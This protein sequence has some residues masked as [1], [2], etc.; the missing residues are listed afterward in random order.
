MVKVSKL[1]TYFLSDAINVDLVSFLSFFEARFSFKV[2]AG[3]F[4]ASLLLCC[5]FDIW[6]TPKRMIGILHTGI[7]LYCK[8]LKINIDIS[9]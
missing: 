1:I 5:S 2:S 3:F 6:S 9:K 8:M 4:F 7:S